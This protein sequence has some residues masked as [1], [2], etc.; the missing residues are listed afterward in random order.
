M[1]RNYSQ[2]NRNRNAIRATQ[3]HALNLRETTNLTLREIARQCGYVNPTT[4][5]PRPSTA[6]EAIRAARLR[7]A[8]QGASNA[9]NAVQQVATRVN[10]TLPSNR[11]FG[12]EAEFFGITRQQAKTALANVGITARI[13]GRNERVNGWKLT[14]DVSVT[15]S[16]TGEGSGL[17]LVSPILRGTRGMEEAIKALKALADAG[18]RVDRSCGLHVHLG[19]DGM[20]GANLIALVD[21]YQAN[22]ASVRKLVANSRHSNNFCKDMT[23]VVRNSTHMRS[24]AN[25]PAQE[26]LLKQS[27]G[28][29]YDRYYS[30][31][32]TSYCKHGTVEFRQHQGTL[33]GKKLE[34][35]VKFLMAMTEKVIGG[36][37]P[38]AHADLPEMLNRL[39]LDSETQTYLAGRA[40][41]LAHR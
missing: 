25:T 6:T 7:R 16:G 22:I 3:D 2:A 24:V 13:A 40:T 1:P 39:G 31:N 30:V 37:S 26:A 14:T 41:A 15:S 10:G 17:E 34:A 33:N 28:N 18:A 20:T 19:A 35:W 9:S 5:E 38:T 23:A 36:M 32:L 11:T 8:E 4:G 27:I 29:L 12:F 21:Y